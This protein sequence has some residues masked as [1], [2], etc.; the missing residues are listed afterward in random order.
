MGIY[1]KIKHQKCLQ[2]L[3]KFGFNYFHVVIISPPHLVNDDIINDSESI[4]QWLV[5]QR[6]LFIPV[7]YIKFLALL[8]TNL[9]H[10]IRNVS[11]GLDNQI[12]MDK[13]INKWFHNRSR[14]TETVKHLYIHFLIIV[15]H[16]GAAELSSSHLNALE[17]RMQS[18]G[19]YDV[20]SLR[21]QQ[22][23]Y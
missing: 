17:T 3:E 6:I 16:I 23:C 21:L 8:P 12:K 5:S 4:G 11:I 2:L 9:I 15:A 10:W 20:N 13:K 18:K 22:V 7:S 19:G 1:K 14:E